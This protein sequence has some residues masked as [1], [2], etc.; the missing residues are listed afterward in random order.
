MTDRTCAGGD[1]WGNL[2]SPFER[3]TGL[4]NPY[5]KTGEEA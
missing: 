4:K 5:R 2:D 3:V 1:E